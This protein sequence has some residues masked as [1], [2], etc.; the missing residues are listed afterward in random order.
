MTY[1]D[2]MG[3]LKVRGCY[4]RE[5]KVQDEIMEKMQSEL[6]RIQTKKQGPD[7]QPTAAPLQEGQDHQPPGVARVI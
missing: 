2:F 4:V 6:R 3:A 7:R 1:L 5:A